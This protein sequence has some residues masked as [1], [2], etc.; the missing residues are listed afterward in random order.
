MRLLLCI[1]QDSILKVKGIP[2]KTDF[3]D[4]CAGETDFTSLKF[5]ADLWSYEASL[6][7]DTSDIQFNSI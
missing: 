3:K 7:S 2:N 5:P 6:R 4:K 1:Q